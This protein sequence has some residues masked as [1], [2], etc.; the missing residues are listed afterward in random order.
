MAMR[1]R[2]GDGVGDQSVKGGVQGVSSVDGFGSWMSGWSTLS[3]IR[4]EW[5]VLGGLATA[6][7]V[8]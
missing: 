8:A 4:R 5:E 7:A 3:S 2:S 6:G 1:R